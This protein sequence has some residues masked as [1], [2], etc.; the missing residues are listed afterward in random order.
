M[1]IEEL[2][3]YCLLKPGVT[4]DTPFGPETLV[5]KVMGKAFLLTSLTFRPFRINLKM[6][7][8]LAGEYRDKYMD[9]QPGYHMNK[10]HWNSVYADNK[11]IPHKEL[12]WMVDHSYEQVIAGL[13]KKLQ[14][15]LNR[16]K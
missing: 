5:F 10:K 2:R 12:L 7:P 3:D 11:T 15:E 4:E 9:V 14:E 16:L 13:S 1:N 6:N 8:E